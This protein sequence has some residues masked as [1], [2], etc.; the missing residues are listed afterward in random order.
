MNLVAFPRYNNC[1]DMGEV[2]HEM[3]EMLYKHQ[4]RGFYG[5]VVMNRSMDRAEKHLL[6]VL[7]SI[8]WDLELIV[9]GC[10]LE[11]EVDNEV[12]ET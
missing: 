5:K 8:K 11:D 3:D 10:I 12:D 6:T 1:H 7:R 2:W 9:F 4:L